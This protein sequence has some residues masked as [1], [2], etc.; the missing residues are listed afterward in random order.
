M[1]YIN[2]AIFGKYILPQVRFHLRLILLLSRPLSLSFVYSRYST[3]VQE[4]ELLNQ[5]WEEAAVG[6]ELG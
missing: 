2:E 1:R 4:I 6:A 3:S 5:S